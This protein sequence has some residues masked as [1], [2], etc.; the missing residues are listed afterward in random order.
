MTL[1]QGFYKE[2]FENEERWIEYANKKLLNVYYL[3]ELK[4][5]YLNKQKELEPEASNNQVLE[6]F[7]NIIKSI[8]NQIDIV[9]NEY[10][11]GKSVDI[12]TVTNLFFSNQMKMENKE[13][14]KDS[15]MD[16]I[17]LQVQKE[18]LENQKKQLLSNN[19]YDD[20][21][22]YEEPDYKSKVA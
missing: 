21:Y 3:S 12:N 15:N 4:E 9:T 5:F 11:E 20:D 14:K 13:E 10:R 7:L 22:L 17:R 6:I 16:I 18:L 2:I 19:L 1:K 8:I